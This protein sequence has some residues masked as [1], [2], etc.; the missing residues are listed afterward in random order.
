MHPF[1]S[2]RG[3][4]WIQTAA[5]ISSH[6]QQMSTVPFRNRATY[7]LTHLQQPGIFT[8]HV[9]SVP[10]LLK[11]VCV[12]VSMDMCTIKGRSMQIVN[13]IILLFS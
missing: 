5:R 13:F 6:A 2:K 7:Q 11:C 3:C 10:G 8:F 4:A 1:S 12:C 9:G